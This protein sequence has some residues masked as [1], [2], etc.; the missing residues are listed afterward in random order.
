MSAADIRRPAS[1]LAD[2]DEVTDAD[3][4]TVRVGD[5]VVYATTWGRSP[6]LRFG[7]VLL[8][9]RHNMGYGPDTVRLRI[10]PERDFYS[11]RGEDE[12]LPPLVSID[13]GL[14]RFVKVSSR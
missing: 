8:I 3:G 13:A 7:E 9:S 14:G 5:R 1:W 11:R 6:H 2:V 12:K 4:Q 10:Q